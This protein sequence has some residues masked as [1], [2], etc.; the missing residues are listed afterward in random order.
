MGKPCSLLRA[1]ML[2]CSFIFDHFKCSIA[3]RD[4]NSLPCPQIAFPVQVAVK[5]QGFPL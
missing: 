2:K 4:F 5:M 1:S 3:I